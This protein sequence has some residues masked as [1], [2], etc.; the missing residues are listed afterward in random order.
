[1]ASDYSPKE[2]TPNLGSE[3]FRGT[4]DMLGLEVN[5][6][7]W[8]KSTRYRRSGVLSL[9]VGSC[10]ILLW[11]F[12]GNPLGTSSKSDW[13][14]STHSEPSIQ[15]LKN[16][17]SSPVPSATGVLECFQVYQPLPTHEAVDEATT[18]DAP[19]TPTSFEVTLMEH[20]F[21]FSYGVPFIGEYGL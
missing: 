3:K 15:L 20:D 2:E 7:G 10:L 9:L 19:I 8:Q 6:K 21:A 5:E 1:M 14:R 16:Q 18:R 4:P 13:T 17:A 11:I 12:R